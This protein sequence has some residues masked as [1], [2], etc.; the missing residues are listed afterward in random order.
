MNDNVKIIIAGILYLV[1]VILGGWTIYNEL[2]HPYIPEHGFILAMGVCPF[3]FPIIIYL[4]E[5]IEK[6]NQ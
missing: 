6:E 2:I 5:I 4:S 3:I 1:W